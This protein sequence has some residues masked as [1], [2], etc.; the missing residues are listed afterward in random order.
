[1]SAEALN[2]LD[3]EVVAVAAVYWADNMIPGD[4]GVYVQFIENVTGSA[5]ETEATTAISDAEWAYI[6]TWDK[7]VPNTDQAAATEVRLMMQH[8]PTHCERQTRE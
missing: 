3:A 1:M 6:V 2:A 8:R 7:M 5:V 4:G